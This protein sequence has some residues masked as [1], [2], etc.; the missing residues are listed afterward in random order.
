MQ[1][2]TSFF[3]PLFL[4]LLPPCP[5]FLSQG[6]TASLVWSSWLTLLASNPSQYSC[7]GHLSAAYKHGPS[8]QGKLMVVHA[9][10]M[11]GETWLAQ[12]FL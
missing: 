4:F 3:L 12:F 6:L 5:P 1:K 2:L 8:V 10:N 9:S 11:F 7:L